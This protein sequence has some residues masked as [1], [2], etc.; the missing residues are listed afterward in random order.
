MARLLLLTF[1]IAW[2]V[3]SV[4]QTTHPAGVTGC[5]AR[6]DFASN[7]QAISLPD[8]SNNNNG[9]VVNNLTATKGFR[10]R[11]NQAYHFNG[12][13]SNAQVPSSTQLN[14]QQISIVALVKFTGFYSGN[15]Q[16]NNIIYKSFTY[17]S[18]GCWGMSVSDQKYDNDYSKYSPSNEQMDFAGPSL[19]G[20]PLP[21]GNF[22][23][24]NQWLLLVT[25]YDG[26]TLKRYQILM[27]TAQ[28]A[29]GITYL[30]K[31]KIG[32]A[33]GTNNENVFIGS[34]Q[35]PSYLFWFN[36]D[37]DD[38][39]IFNKALTD[40]EVQSIYNYLW[41]KG[42][43]VSSPRNMPEPVIS[44]GSGTLQV[45]N[46]VP[47]KTLSVTIYD[48]AGKRLQVH[49]SVGSML[50]LDMHAYAG[51]MLVVRVEQDGVIT[52]KRFLSF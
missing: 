5:I 41:S 35:N 44:A 27:D 30:S 22:I 20:A 48:I 40:A 25:T 3:T 31:G 7:G 33:L 46:P 21:T 38:L 6:W 4:A 8:V 37:M 24:Q 1:F 2:S 29:T 17:Y 45:T 32:A 49:N 52:A 18:P 42:L 10:D 50:S 51:Q 9:G 43:A 34:T 47:G 23:L 13:N 14:P 11:D 39:A 26:D 15:C 12:V 19:T 36:G 28:K 16:T